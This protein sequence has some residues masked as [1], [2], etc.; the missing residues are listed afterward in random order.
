MY[1]AFETKVGET[2]LNLFGNEPYLDINVKV[3][4][5]ELPFGIVPTTKLS[6]YVAAKE[7]FAL[8]KVAEGHGAATVEGYLARV[9]AAPQINLGIHQDGSLICYTSTIDDPTWAQSIQDKGLY[10]G[11]NQASFAIRQSLVPECGGNSHYHR[12]AVV[13]EKLPLLHA[14]FHGHGIRTSQT[15]VWNW[16]AYVCYTAVGAQENTGSFHDLFYT[17]IYPV[18][19][20]KTTPERF[21][22]INVNGSAV[23]AAIDLHTMAQYAHP[24]LGTVYSN[25]CAVNYT[26]KYNAALGNTPFN[27]VREQLITDYGAKIAQLFRAFNPSHAA[28]TDEEVFTLIRA[29]S[30]ATCNDAGV[31]IVIGK[32]SLVGRPLSVCG[33]QHKVPLASFEWDA[34]NPKLFKRRPVASKIMLDFDRHFIRSIF[35]TAIEAQPVGTVK[36]ELSATL[37]R[38]SGSND[39]IKAVFYSAPIPI[40]RALIDSYLNTQYVRGK[41]ALGESTDISKEHFTDEW[42][43][44][45]LQNELNRIKERQ[46]FANFQIDGI[47]A[48]KAFTKAEEIR[49]N[50][51]GH[52]VTIGVTL[53]APNVITEF[54]TFSIDGVASVPEEFPKVFGSPGLVYR[55]VPVGSS[56]AVT[57]DDFAKFKFQDNTWSEVMALED[58]GTTNSYDLKHFVYDSNWLTKSGYPDVTGIEGKYAGQSMFVFGVTT[59]DALEQIFKFCVRFAPTDELLDPPPVTEPEAEG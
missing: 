48:H 26:P 58:N 1:K 53:S 40:N 13:A 25:Q 54:T 12:L 49:S 31:P 41:S 37:T 45:D 43:Y 6:T 33:F 52:S 39:P 35:T 9:E 11:A 4:T 38:L 56:H 59:T 15:M 30:F 19:T 8:G 57:L 51:S 24:L 5:Q 10:T 27:I 55:I 16:V 29:Q 32:A 21:A 34:S 20:G 46:L 22:S 42:S 47:E 17:E 44:G 28:K 7:Q 2:T 18:R 50:G 14:A 23:H 36:D 3:G